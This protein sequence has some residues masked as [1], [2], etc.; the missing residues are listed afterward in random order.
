MLPFSGQR[1]GGDLMLLEDLCWKGQ[2]AVP[3]FEIRVTVRPGNQ[4]S[5]RC[6][7]SRL[8]F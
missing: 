4:V 5:L 6:T 7:A 8:A 2:E 1:G 3:G